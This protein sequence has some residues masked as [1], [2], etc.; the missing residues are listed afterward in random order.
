MATPKGFRSIK[1]WLV[2]GVKTAGAMGQGWYGYE[3]TDDALRITNSR[4]AFDVSHLD[5]IDRDLL[6]LELQAPFTAPE[7]V[8]R[9]ELG[10]MFT[11]WDR[12]CNVEIHPS[13][14]QLVYAADKA[15]AILC[16]EYAEVEPFT[17]LILLD[18]EYLGL[19]ERLYSTS[20]I[21]Y[22]TNFG[23]KKTV[24]SIT[25]GGEIRGVL[26]PVP[27]ASDVIERIRRV[28]RYV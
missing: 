23:A 5:R 7:R 11:D 4:W 26:M 13:D 15:W 16:A 25:V 18:A 8:Q 21:T 22:R 19:T 6:H 20:A 14:L 9:L 3:Y 10:Q 12:E 17:G 27:I 1:S 2:K 24:V 28:A